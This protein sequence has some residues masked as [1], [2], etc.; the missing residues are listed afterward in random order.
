VLDLAFH[1]QPAFGDG[2]VD[3]AVG[4]V[5]VRYQG[6]ERGAADLVVLPAIQQVDGQLVL[7]GAD[8]SYR[9]GDLYG[10][11]TLMGI[12][13]AAAEH[14]RALSLRYR[15]LRRVRKSRVVLELCTDFIDDPLVV[16]HSAATSPSI[17]G[18]WP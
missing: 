16:S 10:G 9:L 2:D 5:G 1:G 18:L 17:V 4:H 14:H 13:D 6:L 3:P 12:A 15:H 11:P 8:T 7:D